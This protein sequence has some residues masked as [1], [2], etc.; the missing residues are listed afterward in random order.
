[1]RSK[2]T[3][4]AAVKLLRYLHFTQ[5]PKKCAELDISLVY[6]LILGSEFARKKNFLALSVYFPQT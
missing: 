2:H 6:F 4:F 5:G 3:E 1:M